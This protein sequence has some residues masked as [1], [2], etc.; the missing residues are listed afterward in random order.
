MTE[1]AERLE[2]E[3]ATLLRDEIKELEKELKKN[4]K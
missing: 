4:A 3:L 1:A 2:F